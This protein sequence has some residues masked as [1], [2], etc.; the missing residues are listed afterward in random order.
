MVQFRRQRKIPGLQTRTQGKDPLCKDSEESRGLGLA[1]LLQCRSDHTISN[2]H[3]CGNSLS[4]A[5]KALPSCVS[6]HLP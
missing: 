4:T 6:G 3:I 1:L 5:R 2:S